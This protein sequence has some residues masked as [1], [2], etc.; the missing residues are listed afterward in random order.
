MPGR[1]KHFAPRQAWVA[2]RPQHSDEWIPQP[3]RQ[4]WQAGYRP[5]RKLSDAA[6]KPMIEIYVALDRRE[7]RI[8]IV[9]LL[10]T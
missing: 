4:Q 7:D 2:A 5:M 10:W 1:Q 9:F 3:A 8:N 6:G